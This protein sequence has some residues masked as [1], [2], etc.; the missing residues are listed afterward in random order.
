VAF[1]RP[2]LLLAQ[3]HGLFLT[4]NHLQRFGHRPASPAWLPATALRAKW[5]SLAAIP[6][7]LPRLFSAGALMVA[8]QLVGGRMLNHCRNCGSP[9]V[10]LVRS[11]QGEF[12]GRCRACG[13]MTPTASR[14][15]LAAQIWNARHPSTAQARRA[16]RWSLVASL[17]ILL[18]L[19][20]AV[21]LTALRFGLR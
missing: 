17:L 21:S 18:A 16:H 4:R 3:E 13:I 11:A 8:A 6:A 12:A 10:E 7:Q 20:A 5:T 19:S 15:A 14:A 2:W 9:Q 1:S